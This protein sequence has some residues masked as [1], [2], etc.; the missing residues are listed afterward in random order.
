M[1][2]SSHAEAEAVNFPAPDKCVVVGEGPI[3]RA[4]AREALTWARYD[5]ERALDSLK[6][7]TAEGDRESAEC[8]HAALQHLRRLWV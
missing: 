6:R 7:R 2:Q 3:A 8:V 4:W 1:H 5:I